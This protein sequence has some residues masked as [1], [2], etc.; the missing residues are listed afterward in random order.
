METQLT[1]KYHEFYS[2]TSTPYATISLV[3]CRHISDM[4][5]V[6]NRIYE[7]ADIITDVSTLQPMEGMKP[8]VFFD[9][10]ATKRKII[11]FVPFFYK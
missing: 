2:T 8:T 11:I 4:V 3:D 6:M 7:S 10:A 5:N 1:K 9:F